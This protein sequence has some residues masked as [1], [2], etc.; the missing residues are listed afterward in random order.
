MENGLGLFPGVE[1]FTVE[2]CFQI[3]ESKGVTWIDIQA[4]GRFRSIAELTALKTISV[5]AD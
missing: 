5:P 1:L 3:T 2:F 4:I